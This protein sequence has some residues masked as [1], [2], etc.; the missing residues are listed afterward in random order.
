MT[1]ITF[2]PLTRGGSGSDTAT[3]TF[4]GDTGSSVLNTPFTVTFVGGTDITTEVSGNN[5]TF[6]YTGSGGVADGDKGDITVSAS[7]ATWTIDNNVVTYAKMQDVSATDRLL[8]RSSIGSGDVEEIACTAFARSI[9]D[10]ADEAT[11]KATVN[12]EIGTDVQ[13]YDATLGALAAY[14]TNGLITQTAA[15]TFTGRT[16]TG[17]SNEVTVTNGDGVSGNPTLSL[18][19]TIDLGGKTSLEIPN[20]AAP[21]V[22]ADGEIA[23]DTSVADFSHGILKYYGSEEMGVVAMPIAEFT[24]PTDVTVPIYNATNDEFNLKGGLEL[25]RFGTDPLNDGTTSPY[26]AGT[27]AP[28]AQTLFSNLT[29][30]TL[31]YQAI[32]VPLDTYTRIGINIH[33]AQASTTFRLGIYTNSNGHPGALVLDAG[34]I[35]S[36][37]TGEKEITISQA[38][39]GKY[40]LVAITDGTTTRATRPIY[41]NDWISHPP[42]LA[43]GAFNPI[44]LSKAASSSEH[45]ALPNPAPSSLSFSSVSVVPGLWVRVV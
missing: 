45:A 29:Q 11:F 30:Y 40:F 7:G 13:A 17:T 36:S 35:D 28:S 23:V 39:A 31:Y 2:E 9:L 37:T 19:S 15:D 22:D 43:A 34:T 25:L 41:I 38:L 4:E 32:D 33:V 5:I 20:S 42:T 1:G 6:N 14:N 18:P 44:F 24:S 3:I 21:T 12:L 16:I 8:G 27:C 10:D 26:I